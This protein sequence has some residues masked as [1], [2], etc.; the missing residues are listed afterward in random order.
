MVLS[1][2]KTHLQFR[3]AIKGADDD[4]ETYISALS[5]VCIRLRS[6]D[7]AS[8]L[9]YMR[10]V[11]KD[12]APLSILCSEDFLY[13]T[14]CETSPYEEFSKGAQNKQSIHSF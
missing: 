3:E 9:L 7:D 5:K 4:K 8:Q 13:S 14:D 6:D 2:P 11:G 1:F 12:K 10:C